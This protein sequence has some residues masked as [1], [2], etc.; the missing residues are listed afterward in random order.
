MRISARL[1]SVESEWAES[2]S[3]TYLIL[4]LADG[5]R[6][7]VPTNDKRQPDTLL[8]RLDKDYTIVVEGDGL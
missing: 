2:D 7:R 1:V 8:K 5:Q 3:E 6:L 4:K